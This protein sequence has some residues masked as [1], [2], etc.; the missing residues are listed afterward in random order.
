MKFEITEPQIEKMLQDGIKAA[1]AS[2]MGDKY[3]AG[4]RLKNSVESAIT[5]SENVITE[6]IKA[7]I[8]QV[9]ASPAFLQTIEKEIAASMA[10]QYRGAFDGVIRAAA[11]NAANTE[12]IAQRVAELTKQAAGVK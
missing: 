1:I 8:S 3:G 9:V 10:S 11:K 2:I 5:K 6:A 4:A 12:V 7:A